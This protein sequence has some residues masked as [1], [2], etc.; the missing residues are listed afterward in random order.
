MGVGQ[1]T[2]MVKEF[3]PHFNVYETLSKLRCPVRK[4]ICLENQK[5][6]DNGQRHRA[7]QRVIMKIHLFNPDNCSNLAAGL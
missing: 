2:T 3:T 6:P 5:K 7:S 4:I 1:K